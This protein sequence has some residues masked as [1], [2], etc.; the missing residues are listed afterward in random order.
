MIK[1][2]AGRNRRLATVR[3]MSAATY[4]T[5]K[6]RGPFNAFFFAVMGGYLDLLLRHRKSRYF[7]DLPDEVV[8]L[9]PGIGANFKYLKPGTRVIAIEPN[10][11]MH[12]RLRA[13][14]EK[15]GIELDLRGIVGEQLDLPANS[16]AAV[17]SSLVL[18]TVTD[19]HQVVSEV[20]RVLR[21][22]GRYVFVEHVAAKN[23]K[24]IRWTQR[25]VRKPWAWVFEGC[26]CE[27]D[28]AAVIQQAEFHSVDLEHYRI[29]S[30]FVPFNTHLAGS[31]VKAA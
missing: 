22:G 29:R 13:R 10:E 15:H 8:E 30:P 9:G 14:A 24:F 4:E 31:A 23:N 21:P 11:A 20:H 27:R 16:A 12:A 1:A 17:V 7:A 19:P 18:C 5:N 3:I 2:T 28:L 25:A 26:S 6:V